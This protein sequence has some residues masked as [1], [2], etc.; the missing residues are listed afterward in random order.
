MYKRQLFVGHVGDRTQFNVGNFVGKWDRLNHLSKGGIIAMQRKLEELGFDVG[1]ADGLIGH[2]TRRSVGLWQ[3]Q[4][5][6]RATCYP[7][8]EFMSAI[9]R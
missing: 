4:N 8:I 5:G 9:L 1:G 6:Q 2:K 3:E 7:S